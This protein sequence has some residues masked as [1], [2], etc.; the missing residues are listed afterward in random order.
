[1]E[2]GGAARPAGEAAAA[3]GRRH[4]GKTLLA[5]AAS[6]WAGRPSE[7]LGAP[8]SSLALQQRTGQPKAA[9]KRQ[10]G[11][12][13]ARPPSLCQRLRLP[14]PFTSAGAGRGGTCW[15]KGIGPDPSAFRRAGACSG[16]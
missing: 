5:G 14:W 4:S 11:M 16:R 8:T 7:L 6:T 3:A 15:I 10:R 12:K 13:R 9:N 2:C 1:M